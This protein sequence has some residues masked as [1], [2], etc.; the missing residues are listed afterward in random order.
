MTKPLETAYLRSDPNA[1]LACDQGWPVDPKQAAE[2]GGPPGLNQ[3]QFVA[4]VHHAFRHLSDP[5]ALRSNRL[6]Q[7]KLVLRRCGSDASSRQR[8]QVLQTLLHETVARLQQSSRRQKQLQA[9]AITYLESLATPEQA[10]GLIGLPFMVYR[11]Y[12]H[13]GLN[14]VAAHLWQQELTQ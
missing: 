5:Q 9:L 2:R 1:P 7:T 14:A 4:A 13:A 12:L 8:I 10:A 6:L 3:A 11:R